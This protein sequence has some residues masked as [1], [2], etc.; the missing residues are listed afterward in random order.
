MSS[1]SSSVA[2]SSTESDQ[3]DVKRSPDV[4]KSKKR[5]REKKKKDRKKKKKKSKKKRKRERKRKRKKDKKHKKSTKRPRHLR[6]IDPEGDKL[7]VEEWK[8]SNS[9]KRMSTVTASPRQMTDAKAKEQEVYMRRQAAIL[10]GQREA[11]DFQIMMAKRK[12]GQLRSA[13]KS[14]NKVHAY[15]QKERMKIAALL[16][17]VGVNPNTHMKK[18]PVQRTAAEVFGASTAK[19]KANALRQTKPSF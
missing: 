17:S 11:S 9:A 15:Q 19:S 3:D 12:R 1:S 18:P 4:E 5:K 16:K 7:D 8:Y 14:R 10:S 2:S 13:I 6:D